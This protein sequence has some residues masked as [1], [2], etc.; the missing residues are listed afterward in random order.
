MSSGLTTNTDRSS[1]GS[2]V[3]LFW[4][5]I[6]VRKQKIGHTP[7]ELHKSLRVRTLRPNVGTASL[8]GFLGMATF[9]KCPGRRF[10]E[11]YGPNTTFVTRILGKHTEE[12]FFWYP[13]LVLLKKIGLLNL[14]W[15]EN[16]T[17]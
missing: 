14:L 15:L 3:V 9:T 13:T 6:I 8:L 17:W 10:S 2:N 11:P 4:E 12:L 5:Y 7:K 16:R 1:W